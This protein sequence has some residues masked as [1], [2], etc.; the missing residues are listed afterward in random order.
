MKKLY[1]GNLPYQASE[2]QLESWFVQAGFTPDAVTIIR[3]RFSGES[4]GFGFV[5]IVNDDDAN[6]A[7]QACNGQ[8]FL[9]RSLIVNEARPLRERG[10]SEG[11]RGAGGGG[12]DR[13]RG[14][15]RPRY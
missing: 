7:I 1:V 2:S 10:P 11:R 14:G 9:G 5:D 15:G 6:R 13:K 4:R 12:A 3:D 8:D